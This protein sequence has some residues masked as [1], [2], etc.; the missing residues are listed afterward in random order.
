MMN[1]KV[2]LA[3]YIFLHLPEGAIYLIYLFGDTVS[4]SDYMCGVMAEV[5]MSFFHV[6]GKFKK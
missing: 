2:G 1:Q 3:F 6:S 4:G 5:H